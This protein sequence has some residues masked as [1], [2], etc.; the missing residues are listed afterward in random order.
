MA[1]AQQQYCSISV[2]RCLE[3]PLDCGSPPLHDDIRIH[4]DAGGDDGFDGDAD[5]GADDDA[6]GAR[7]EEVLERSDDDHGSGRLGLLLGWSAGPRS[8]SVALPCNP[9]KK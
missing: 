9:D 8:C 1:G 2:L 7:R 4:D 3:V 5:G 6:G